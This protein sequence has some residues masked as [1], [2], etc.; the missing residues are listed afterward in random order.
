MWKYQHYHAEHR[1]STEIK[2]LILVT[3]PCLQRHSKMSRM[4]RDSL[5]CKRNHQGLMA[6]ADED[7]Q[8]HSNMCIR[9]K[10]S[11]KEEENS[12]VKDNT[13]L[14]TNQYLYNGS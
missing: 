1:L 13:G 10:G 3:Q 5:C 4:A 2:H 6:R 8:T 14:R 11:T 12:K 7:E 9:V